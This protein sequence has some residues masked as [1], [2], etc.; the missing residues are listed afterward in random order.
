MGKSRKAKEKEQLDIIKQNRIELIWYWIDELD[1][2]IML[3]LYKAIKE[4]KDYK[5]LNFGHITSK[6]IT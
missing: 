6:S 4:Y 3:Y 1:M 5:I 2:N